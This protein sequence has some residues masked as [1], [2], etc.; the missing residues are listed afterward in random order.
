MKPVQRPGVMPPSTAAGRIAVQIALSVIGAFSALMLIAGVIAGMLAPSPR[1]TPAQAQAREARAAANELKHSRCRL[2]SMCEKYGEVRQRCATAGN[3]DNCIKV[4]MGSA[5][6]GK[7]DCTDD[8]KVA[9][10]GS[11][12]AD[13]PNRL[14]SFFSEMF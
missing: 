5:N 7:Y 6:I 8:G 3:F 1:E 4:K 9:W 12:P 11:T 2:Q 14:Q 10:I 13:M